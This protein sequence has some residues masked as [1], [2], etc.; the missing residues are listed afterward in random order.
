MQMADKDVKSVLTKKASFADHTQ[1][2]ARN[3]REVG[4]F[5]DAKVH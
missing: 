4:P 3:A 5:T 2:L 1:T